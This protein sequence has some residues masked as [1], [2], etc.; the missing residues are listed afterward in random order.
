[1]AT[2][3]AQDYLWPQHHNWGVKEGNVLTAPPKTDDY[4]RCAWAG[5]TYYV[6][7]NIDLQ[8]AFQLAPMKNIF[9]HKS[10]ALCE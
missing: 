7:R 5:G 10:G 8:V 9:S 3:A 2:F 1:V 6:R 4:T